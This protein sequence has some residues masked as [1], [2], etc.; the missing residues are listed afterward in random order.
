MILKNNLK[1]VRQKMGLTQEEL[2]VNIG[3]SKQTIISIE[4]LFYFEKKIRCKK[5]FKTAKLYNFCSCEQKLKP[6]SA[7]LKTS[8]FMLN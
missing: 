4:K 1:E 7:S 3:V 5:I 8:I 2:A 6:K